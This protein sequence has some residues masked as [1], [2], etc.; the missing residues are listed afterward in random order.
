[1]PLWV[2]EYLKYSS[3]SSGKD[4]VSHGSGELAVLYFPQ[5]EESLSGLTKGFI[6]LMK[7]VKHE[8]QHLKHLG[9]SEFGIESTK[10]KYSFLLQKMYYRNVTFEEFCF[11]AAPM[12]AHKQLFPSSK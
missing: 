7:E 9:K 4:I 10:S 5:L 1:M 11:V 2:P 12:V 3:Q 6:Q 8:F